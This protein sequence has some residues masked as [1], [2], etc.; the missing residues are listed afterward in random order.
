MVFFIGSI[1]FT[2]AGYSQ[3]Y[4]SI[5]SQTA[6]AASPQDHKRAWFAWQPGRLDFWITFSQLL[7][8]LMFNLNTI[9]AYLG[10]GW[11]GWLCKI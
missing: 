10:L 11:L 5:N 4:Q 8:T 2:S 9:D 6:I 1:F 3:Y 7:G